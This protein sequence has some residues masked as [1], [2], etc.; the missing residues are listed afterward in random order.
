MH[1]AIAVIP[2]HSLTLIVQLVSDCHTHL[3]ILVNVPVLRL[4]AYLVAKAE[5]PTPSLCLRS[6]DCTNRVCNV[7]LPY[8]FHCVDVP[9]AQ[10]VNTPDILYADV[11]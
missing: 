5:E 8:L 1:I 4:Y 2:Y 3:F 6:M 9:C 11:F 7:R 10:I